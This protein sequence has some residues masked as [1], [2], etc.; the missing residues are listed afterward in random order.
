MTWTT[1]QGC[2]GCREKVKGNR[3]KDCER[4]EVILMVK[5]EKREVERL[6]RLQK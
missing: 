2:R 1:L 4:W 5:L 3:D 6:E